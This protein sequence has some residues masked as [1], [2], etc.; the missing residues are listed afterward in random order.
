MDT[1]EDQKKNDK[2]VKRRFGEVTREDRSENGLSDNDSKH[3][4]LSG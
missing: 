1:K 4:S 3:S 2:S